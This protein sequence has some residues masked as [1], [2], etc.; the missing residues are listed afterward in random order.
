MFHPMPTTTSGFRKTR[1]GTMFVPLG[2]PLNSPHRKQVA[3]LGRARPERLDL[4][5]ACNA[6]RISKESP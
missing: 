4:R 3:I 5:Q 1:H 2:N 6:A